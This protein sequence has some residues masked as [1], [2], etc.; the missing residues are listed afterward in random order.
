MISA[1][2]DFYGVNYYNPHRVADPRPRSTPRGVALERA[3]QAGRRGG[4]PP[5][6]V[7]LARRTRRAAR[8][9]PACGRRT[10]TSCRRSTSPRAAVRTT[11]WWPPTARC[12]T[13]TG[14]P[15]STRTCGRCAQAVDEGVDVR[16]YY[17]W[18]LLDNFEWAE[19]YTKRFGL[20]HVDYDTQQ[21][22]PKDSYGWYRDVIAAH[23]VSRPSP[24]A[25]GAGPGR[26]A[27][28]RVP[29][30]WVA[31]VTLAGLGLWAG[32]FGPIQVLLA[33]QAQVVSPG[34]KE[35]VFGVGDRRRVGGRRWSR[36]RCSAR[37]RTGPPPGSAAGVPWVVV[38][39]LLGALALVLL[40]TAQSILAMVLAWC[41]AQASLNAMFAALTADRP[42]PRAGPRA[43]GRRRLGR[44]A[45]RRSA[46]SAGSASRTATGRRRGRLLRDGGRGRRAR[47]ALRRSAAA[48]CAAQ[49]APAGLLV[50]GVRPLVL[51]L[52]A[53]APGL[54]AGPG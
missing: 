22:T 7:R 26:A 11:T 52:P 41:L 6:G 33:Q 27:A 1:P 23:A 12:T 49:G 14:S 36:T 17:T 34:H 13:Q 39:A 45:L 38:G 48:T 15:T 32:F 9:A 16:G 50:A 4:I 40:A 20:V 3:V 51:D 19:G 35:F 37:C 5:H 25:A 54:R 18:S 44:G 29:R 2:L 8:A 47:D 21:R 53:A 30:R 10:A 31:S 24:P 42:R 46:S 28:S 43:R